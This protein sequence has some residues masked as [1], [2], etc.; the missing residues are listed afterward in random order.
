MFILLLITAA[1]VLIVILFPALLE[2]RKPKD[3]G[4][5]RILGSDGR[6]I[7]EFSVLMSV[8]FR[9]NSHE[10]RL[11]EDIETPEFSPSPGSFLSMSLPDIEF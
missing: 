10:A 2:L 11:L 8:Y 9:E 5:R 1:I 3:A 4:P 7:I 6:E